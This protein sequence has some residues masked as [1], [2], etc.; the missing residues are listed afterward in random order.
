MTNN[1]SFK[2]LCYR[3]P[4]DFPSGVLLSMQVHLPV[5]IFHKVL[6]ALKTASD[7][8]LESAGKALDLSYEIAATCYLVWLLSQNALSKNLVKTEIFL[9]FT[10]HLSM[11]DFITADSFQYIFLKRLRMVFEWMIRSEFLCIQ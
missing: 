2:L 11:E 6:C 9:H 4:P 3:E 8:L 7:M 5:C 10:L 1:R